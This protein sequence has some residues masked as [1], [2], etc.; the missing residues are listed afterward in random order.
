PVRNITRAETTKLTLVALKSFDIKL[1][2]TLGYVLQADSKVTA[3]ILDSNKQEVIKFFENQDRLAGVNKIYWNGKDLS[4][5]FASKGIYYF[6]VKSIDEEDETVLSTTLEIIDSVD[7]Y[8]PKKEKSNFK[9][10]PEIHWADSFIK[11]GVEEKLV[12]GYP[13]GT[14]RPD[15]TIPRY[16]MAVVGVQALGLDIGLAKEELPFKDAEQVPS[17]AK[18]Y[19]YLAYTYGLLPKFPD[20]NFYP[21]RPISRAEIALFVLELIN[22]QKIDARVRG[23]VTEGVEKLL[24][25]GNIIK[26]ENN[27]FELLLNKELSQDITFGFDESQILNSYFDPLYSQKEVKRSNTKF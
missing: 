15:S 11:A 7:N 23:S 27:T 18:K 4:G 13:D 5:N 1:G 12:S 26:P 9:D 8:R 2:V 20:N 10:V 14:F 19:V 25:D 24:I 22:K 3:R 21:N 16:E 17:W 6:E